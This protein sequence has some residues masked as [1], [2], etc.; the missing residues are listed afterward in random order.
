[1]TRSTSFLL[2]AA[3]LVQASPT[4]AREVFS[5]V[6]REARFEQVAATTKDLPAARTFYR[7]RLGLRLLFEANHMLFFD[8]GGTRL[9]ITEDNDR[10]RSARPSSILYFDTGDFAQARVRLLASGARLV[11]GVETVDVPSAGALK[12]QQF[13]DPDGNLLAIMG[14]MPR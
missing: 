7:D 2:S 13:E 3:A 6:L 5:P 11:G 10:Q 14:V 9:M 8:V 4:T 12:L 1:M